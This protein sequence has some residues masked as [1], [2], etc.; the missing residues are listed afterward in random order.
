MQCSI[1]TFVNNLDEMLS[2]IKPR[3]DNLICLGDCPL[4]NRQFNGNHEGANRALRKYRHTGLLSDWNRYKELRNFIVSSIRREKRAYLNSLT[5]ENNSRKMW[6]ALTDLNIRFAHQRSVPIHLA[7]PNSVG[8]YKP[9]FNLSLLIV[10]L[11]RS[12][13]EPIV[14]LESNFLFC[15]YLKRYTKS[16]LA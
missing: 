5:T 3:V 6:F 14:T 16:Y 1:N 13:I 10:T 12:I 7:D 15:L 11:R 4:V 2:N 8:N 9:L